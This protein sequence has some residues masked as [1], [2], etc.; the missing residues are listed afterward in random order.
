MPAST[1]TSAAAAA[2]PSS[3]NR[4]IVVS[5]APTDRCR[6]RQYRQRSRVAVLRASSDRSPRT[7]A[8][9]TC[10]FAQG[11]GEPLAL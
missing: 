4:V 9:A 11:L 3:P 5:S 8:D 1:F 6:V 7:P 2:R 10:T